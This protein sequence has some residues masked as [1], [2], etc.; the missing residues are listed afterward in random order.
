LKRRGIEDAKSRS[1]NII[2][3]GIFAALA[4]L[5]TSTGLTYLGASSGGL[6]PDVAIGVLSVKIAEGLLGYFGKIVFAVI[7][8]LACITTSVGL[9]SAAGD[10]FEQ[11]SGGKIKYKFTVAA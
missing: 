11:M 3:I 8:A 7:I 9:T 10:T 4:L 2:T 6:F 1:S 5:L